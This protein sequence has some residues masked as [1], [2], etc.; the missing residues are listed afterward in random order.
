MQP[1]IPPNPPTTTIILYRNRLTDE[2]KN[3]FDAFEDAK[4]RSIAR[5][6]EI[7]ASR[8]PL[9]WIADAAAR[10]RAIFGEDPLPY[11]IEANRPTLEAFLR[12]AHE[13]GVC[14][15]RLAPED[16]FPPEVQTS[17]RV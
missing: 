17:F 4:R 11:G 8:F 14:H 12:F 15:R 7:T 5:S 16:L 9:P 3:L 13:Q 1:A 2:A 6:R 10:A